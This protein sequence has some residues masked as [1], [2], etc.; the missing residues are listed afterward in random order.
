MNNGGAERVVGER[1]RVLEEQVTM[2]LLKPYGC[3]VKF[4]HQVYPL[5]VHIQTCSPPVAPPRLVLVMLML[6]DLT[7]QN[8]YF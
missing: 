4:S 2:S 3:G 7:F 6:Y 1:V 5:Y 8:N